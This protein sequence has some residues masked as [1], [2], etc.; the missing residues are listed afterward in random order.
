MGIA[1]GTVGI[2]G[3]VNVLSLNGHTDAS[4]AGKV[5]AGGDV[6]VR[7]TDDTKLM[8]IDGG[9]GVGFVGVGAGVGVVVLDKHTTALIGDGADVTALGNGTGFTVRDGTTTDGNFGTMG[10]TG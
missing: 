5:R 4:I 7:A 6:L 3:G 9:L 10:P 2:G 8:V 1:G